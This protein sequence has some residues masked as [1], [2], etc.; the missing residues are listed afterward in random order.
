MKAAALL[1]AMLLVAACQR[2][3]SEAALVAGDGPTPS[4]TPAPAAPE[5]FDPAEIIGTWRPYSDGAEQEFGSL[6]ITEGRIAFTNLGTADY[7]LRGRYAVLSWR[8]FQPAARDLCGDAPPEVVEFR[9]EDK[10]A[11]LAAGTPGQWLQ[12]SFFASARAI[13][14]D[15]STS[16]ELCR[17]VT[18]SR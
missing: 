15:R 8:E 11:T 5:A 16:N 10:N 13:G 12:L 3:P 1:A 2:A 9:P 17:I 14:T 4:A 18:W 7:Q 6:A